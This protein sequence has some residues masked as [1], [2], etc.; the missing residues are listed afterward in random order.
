MP[1][2][3]IN[4]RNLRLPD[5]SLCSA[6]AGTGKTYTLALR[7]L[8]LV[9]SNRITHNGLQNILAITFTNNAAAEMK[10]RIIRF[11]KNIYFGDEEHTK[12]VS[13]IL[14]QD[15]DLLRTKS[16]ELLT[17]I[18]DNYSDFQVKTID[19]FAA[20][21]F[22]T[23]ALEF[24][25]HPDFEIGVSDTQLV[26][27][28]LDVFARKL[29]PGSVEAELFHELIRLI[30]ENR[31]HDE[32]F[33][34]NPYSRISSEMLKLYRISANK[35][36][37]IVP[38][39]SSTAALSGAKQEL[40]AKAEELRS[41]LLSTGLSV[42]KL[43]LNDIQDVLDGNIEGVLARTEKSLIINAPKTKEEKKKYSGIA[44][45]A[46]GDLA[47][48][49]A[50]LKKYLVASAYSYY[51]PYVQAL[52][53]VKKTIDLVKREVGEISLA[54]VSRELLKELNSE[55]V[56]EV[57][58][59]L[60][61]T[62][63]HYLIDEFQDTSPVQWQMLK[64]LIENS[65]SQGGSLFVVGD[66]K[67]SIYS[68]RGA[69]WHI[70]DSIVR[71]NP[72]PA[73][74][75]NHLLLTTNRRSCEK[76]L[77]FVYDVFAKNIPAM[78]NEYSAAAQVSGL[79]DVKVDTIPE[80]SGKGYV[81]VEVVERNEEIFPEKQKILS[82]IHDCRE[83]GYSWRDI[84]VL[85]LRNS[86]VI[87]VSS[88]LNA[89]SIPFI[90]HSSLDIRNRKIIGE[91]LALLR[92]LDSPIDDLSFSTVLLSEVYE[93]LTRS[94]NNQP[95]RS[96]FENFLLTYSVSR[97]NTSVLYRFF[98]SS[99]PGLWE[100]HFAKLFSRVGYLPLYDLISEVCRVFNIFSLCKN[101]EAAIIKLLEVVQ[102]FEQR[103]SNSLRDFLEF[104]DADN[105]SSEWELDAPKEIDA[106]SVMTVHKAKGLGFPVVVVL[107]YDKTQRS[108]GYIAEETAS[109]LALVRVRKKESERADSLRKL[110]EE[111][112]LRK[113]VDY[114][115]TLYVAFT[116]ATTEMYVV[117][118]YSKLKKAAEKNIPSSFFPL[119]NYARAERPNAPAAELHTERNQAT[120]HHTTEQKAEV[121][122]NG[123]LGF[124]ETRRGDCF[125]LL[126]SRIEFLDT[127]IA[128]T[129]DVLLPDVIEEL[130]A[131]QTEDE[132]KHS[133]TDFFSETAIEKYF[134]RETGRSILNEHEFVKADGSLFRMDRIVIDPNAVTIIDYKTGSAEKQ[135]KYL[136]Q[137]KNYMNILAELFPGKIIRGVI[138][139][140][141][142]KSLVE[143]R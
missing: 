65:L 35:G 42:N 37:D 70:M 56:P 132:I 40:K 41:F 22:K 84:A 44:G 33:F 53:E 34:W 26:N 47:E 113:C 30:E 74:N 93:R 80:H 39:D 12:A 136:E 91:I 127:G 25:Y 98:Q 24:G 112:S 6:S 67:Q 71:E 28:A 48:W 19:S 61:E 23:T 8:Q 96:A 1:T 76:V 16:E 58:F 13:T 52:N 60:G 141:D 95:A 111:Q 49:N 79:S 32:P 143:V 73:A 3:L 29:R 142:V 62:I 77:Q 117:S 68:F 55:R 134:Q 121:V 7:F 106:V 43:F 105:E 139:Y 125:H 130:G 88:W 21:V 75:R 15:S 2:Q 66:M 50:L 36:R 89:Q 59:T 92:F 5:L 119:K 27:H 87:T 110:Y 64:P 135:G 133:L 131:R 9:F 99:Y 86:D 102:S 115:N 72:F 46:A 54:D 137:V 124:A 128:S 10:Q 45:R 103:G 123:K 4:D 116:R 85:T 122:E 57:Y 104:V 138:A 14:D 83:R 82:T 51:L 97:G 108:Y 140:I 11:L 94:V 78:N 120:F 109:G 114:L 118:V 129:V 81:E 63:Y 31:S 107:L 126:L 100:N 20:S 101:E 18:L 69:D 90:S 38:H 17:T